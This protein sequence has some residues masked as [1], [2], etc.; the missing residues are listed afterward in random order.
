MH[1]GPRI[2]VAEDDA[3]FRRVIEFTISRAGFDVVGVSNGRDALE[4]LSSGKFDGLVTDHQMPIMSGIE[5]L[6]HVRGD[7]E[8]SGLS[9]ILCT[10]KGLELDSEYLTQRYKLVAVL[11]KPFSPRQLAGLLQQCCAS[12]PVEFSSGEVVL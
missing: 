11:H 3:V 4:A 9:I 8:W 12:S 7:D 5:L 6:N 10:A 1:T 2:L